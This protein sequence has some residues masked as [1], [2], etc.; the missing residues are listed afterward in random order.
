[1]NP[2]RTMKALAVSAALAVFVLAVPA[3]AT[4]A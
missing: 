2:V 4:A 1:M 3:T